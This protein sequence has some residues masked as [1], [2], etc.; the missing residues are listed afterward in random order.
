MPLNIL[1]TQELSDR[2]V[3]EIETKLDRSTPSNP[4]SLIRVLSIMLAMGHTELYKFAVERSLQNFA[5]TAGKVKLK[6]IGV[7]WGV[8]YN[9]AEQAVLTVTI[10]TEVGASI[11]QGTGFLGVLNGERYYTNYSVVATGAST[12][13]SITSENFGAVGNLSNGETLGISSQISGVGSIATVTGTDNTG[14]DSEDIEDYRQRVLFEIR[15]VKGGGNATDYKTWGEEV[16]GVRRIYPYAGKPVESPISYPGDRT[17]YV[18]ATTDVDE[19]GIAPGALLTEVRN[20][21]NN[22]PVT[23]RSRPPLGITN[24]TL[25]VQ[26]IIR[27]SFFVNVSGITIP[28][29]SLAEAKSDIETF[30]A[31]YFLSVRPYVESID[32]VAEKNNILTDLTVSK[33]VQDVLST[34][35][36]T[37]E[38]ATFG[39][40][41]VSPLVP[42]STYTLEPNELAKLGTVTY[43]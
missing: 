16:T 7:E 31:L 43:E 3:S 1:T 30:L 2:N 21:I 39:I 33:I 28:T 5:L 24:D 10:D 36:G 22:D 8:I 19:D 18:E 25:T 14:A 41:G 40:D 26:S 12:E 11:P 9:P 38:S 29:D 13:L 23:G 32:I 35:G 42:T 37:A 34:Y 6:E 4:M 27:T 20:A 15:S 17:I